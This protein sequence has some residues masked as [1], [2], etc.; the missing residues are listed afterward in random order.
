[1]YWV[2]GRAKREK[3]EKF[4]KFVLE[5]QSEK[6][7]E[8]WGKYTSLAKGGTYSCLDLISMVLYLRGDWE[9]P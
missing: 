9:C 1:M 7:L 3:I 8:N 4:S 6:D 2:S 5:R